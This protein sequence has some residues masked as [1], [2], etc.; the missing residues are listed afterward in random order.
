MVQEFN[1]EL[2]NNQEQRLP[3]VLI[4]D[5]SYSMHG[6]PIRQLEEGLKL[7]EDDIKTD[8]D[9]KQKVQIMVISCGG[10]NATKLT[11]WIDAENFICPELAANGATPMGSAVNMAIEEIENRKQ[12]YRDNGISYLKPWVFI[13][14]DGAPN[15]NWEEPARNFKNLESNG[16]FST[17]TIAVEDADVNILS[18]FSL[19]SPNKLNGIEFKKLFEWISASVKIGSQKASDSEKTNLPPI[20]WTSV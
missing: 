19:R 8:D 20:D 17:F 15:D 9:A 2:M 13:I 10:D 3:C 18:E 1:I 16:K 5:T 14:S 11:D 4:L 7:F 12:E 6:E